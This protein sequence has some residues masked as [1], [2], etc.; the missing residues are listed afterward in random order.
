MYA[1]QK[2]V[3]VFGANVLKM[4]KVQEK[5]SLKN[6]LAIQFIIQKYLER[7]FILLWR[8]YINGGMYSKKSF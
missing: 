6:M 1:K 8:K 4:E 7:M 5:G 2:D 3:N